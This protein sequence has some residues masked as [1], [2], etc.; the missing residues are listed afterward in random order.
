MRGLSTDFPE[1]VLT[2]PI[3][4][5]AIAGVASG[6]ALAGFRPIAEVM[7]GDFLS[8]CF[9]QILNHIAKYEAMY[10]G[11]A[12]CPV[13]IRTPSGGHRGY[14]PTHSQSLEKHFVGIPHLNVVAA[15]LYHDPGAIF[16][17]LLS[18]SAPALYIEHKLLY[19]QELMRPANGRLGAAIA[20]EDASLGALPTIT[21]SYVP[22]SQCTA[23]VL[24]YGYQA[25]LAA[26]VVE[27]LAMEDE[28]F[29]ELVVPAQIAPIDWAPIERSV[30]AT[31]SLITIEEGTSGWSWGT[32]V[33]A[34]IGHRLFGKLR[35]PIEVVASA[36]EVIP[37]AKAKEREVLVG[38]PQIRR[39]VREVAA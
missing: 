25:F 9:D 8:L 27:A 3:S 14:G 21:L 13:I 22:R 15:S 6:L 39:A 18:T 36:A 34:T 20:G 10:A 37:S 30:L 4:E 35:R 28:T 23:T 29:V 12:T 24:A 31:R 1:R 33:A 2:T 32:E 26:Q 7:F 38:L 19:P 16:A 11:Q 17:H 5:G